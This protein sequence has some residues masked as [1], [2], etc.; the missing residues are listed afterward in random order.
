MTSL[1]RDERMRI[2][3]LRI[4]ENISERMQITEIQKTTQCSDTFMSCVDEWRRL[5]DENE[6]REKELKILIEDSCKKR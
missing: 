3:L 1:D 2:L 6:D 5:F 4:E